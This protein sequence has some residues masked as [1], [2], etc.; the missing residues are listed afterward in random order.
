[1]NQS[2]N[3]STRRRPRPGKAPCPQK[4]RRRRS[5]PN[6]PQVLRAEVS[7]RQPQGGE[8]TAS[9]SDGAD[10]VKE[11]D[12]LDKGRPRTRWIRFWRDVLAEIG[13]E[14]AQTDGQ[15]GE[16]EGL[17]GADD[18]AEIQG[19]VPGGIMTFD[20][21]ERSERERRVRNP[22][23]RARIWRAHP[24]PGPAGPCRRS[25]ALPSREELGI[26]KAGAQGRPD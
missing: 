24:G 26:K 7:P 23:R 13:E 2:S 1:M 6:C 8:P 17:C 22:G 16:G 4:R 3:R 14:R 20:R 11:A 15:G 25:K 10:D 5:R 12:H 19:E 9:K 21:R 18:E